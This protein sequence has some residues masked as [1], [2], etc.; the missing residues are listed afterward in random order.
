MALYCGIDGVKRK[1]KK[2]YVGIN[3]EK[4]EIKKLWSGEN[5]IKK[6]IFSSESILTLPFVTDQSS[7]LKSGEFPLNPG[8]EYELWLIGAGGNGGHGGN[9]WGLY[10]GGG[11]G[12]GGTGG[13]VYVR[14]IAAENSK[15]IWDTYS[16]SG[17]VASDVSVYVGT[18]E[19]ILLSTLPGGNGA[20]GEDASAFRPTPDGGL[21]GI[22]GQAYLTIHSGIETSVLESSYSNGVSKEGSAGNDNGASAPSPVDTPYTNPSYLASAGQAAYYSIDLSSICLGNAGGGGNHESPGG[23]GAPGGLICI[24]T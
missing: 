2:L 17:N 4:K 23:V 22:A 8:S 3:G 9:G 15:I 18:Q 6:L 12:C 24:E 11:G 13:Y 21:N 5:G 19:E 20:D 1:I 14:F 10:R 16:H 7:P